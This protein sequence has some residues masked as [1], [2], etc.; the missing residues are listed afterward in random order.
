MIS[1]KRRLSLFLPSLAGGG[2]EKAMINLAQGLAQRGFRVDLVLARAEGPYLAQVPDSV[3]VV[4]LGAARMLLSLPALTRYLREERPDALLS[5]LDYAN[6]VALW[7]RRFAAGSTLLSVNE[8]NTISLTSR[9]STQRRQRLVPVLIKLFYRW[10]DIIIGNSKGVV[11]DLVSITGLPERRLQ[12]IYNPIVTSEL[13]ELMRSR[14]DHAW[15]KPG[16]LPVVLAVGRLTLQKDFP[17]LIRAF[18]IARQT[19]P[20]R[21]LILGEGPSR[22]ALQ[23]LVRELGLEPHVDLPG[24]VR[25][26][27]AYMA[28]ATAYVL[29][30]RWEGLPSVLIEALACGVPVIATDCPSGP[31]EILA[32]GKYGVLVPMQDVSALAQKIILA[33]NHDLPRPPRESWQPYALETVVDQYLQALGL[34]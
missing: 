6:I 31:R 9:H 16:E 15:L 23:A 28:K 8:Q 4:D 30:S 19:H 7:A 24:F 20:A 21:L 18:A 2:A 5:T 22:P 1:S 10:A 32:D 3:R 11:Q 34:A 27:Y 29:S 33:L 25:N 14:P 26:P 17:S 12:V 13:M